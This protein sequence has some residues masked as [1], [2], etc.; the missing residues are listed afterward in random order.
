MAQKLIR[1]AIVGALVWS[2]AACGGG[3]TSTPASPASAT[4]VLP[5]AVTIAAPEANSVGDPVLFSTDLIEPNAGLA[6]AWSF[7]DGTT[8][9][10]ANPRHEY[11]QPG[12]YLVT[13]RVTSPDGTQLQSARNIRVALPSNLQNA[14]CNET[15]VKGWCWQVPTTSGNTVNGTFFLDENLGWAYGSNG[16][17]LKT[18]DAGQ[19]WMK[20][21][22]PTQQE[23]LGIKF[24]D[25][26]YGLAIAA[27]GIALVTTDG[28]A[29]WKS[30]ATE[31]RFNSS[32]DIQSIVFKDSTLLIVGSGMVS[33]ST[34]RADTWS[35]INLLTSG[36][37]FVAQSGEI[38]KRE[39][40]S[41]VVSRDF[42]RN[43]TPS[44]SIPYQAQETFIWF[45]D[46]QRGWVA[47]HET[48]DNIHFTSIWKTVDGGATWAKVSQVQRPIIT[49]ANAWNPDNVLSG[50]RFLDAN[51]GW[52]QLGTATSDPISFVTSDGG[53]TWSTLN[54]PCQSNTLMILPQPNHQPDSRLMAVY[55]ASENAPGA[56]YGTLNNGR[57]W[58]PLGDPFALRIPVTTDGYIEP[59]RAAYLGGSSYLVRAMDGTRITR[60]N[61]KTWNLMIQGTGTRQGF[62]GVSFLDAQRGFALAENQKLLQTR[63]GGRQWTPVPTAANLSGLYQPDPVNYFRF[64]SEQVGWRLMNGLISKTNDGGVTWVSINPIENFATSLFMLTADRGWATLSDGSVVAIKN[65]VI[66]NTLAQLSTGLTTPTA[67]HFVSE[68]LGFMGT[69]TGVIRKTTDGGKTW[70]AIATDAKEQIR[71]IA[72][73]DEQTGWAISSYYSFSGRV[74][75]T[76]DGGTTWSVVNAPGSDKGYSD[77]F[78]LDGQHVWITGGKG[79]IVGSTDG[80]A[81]WVSQTQGVSND[82]RQ[83]VFVNTKVGWAVGSNGSILTTASG[84][85]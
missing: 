1:F 17:V 10:E 81:S 8:S 53:A 47:A 19:S 41:I 38:W 39:L 33:V 71:K 27:N 54:Q 65:G 59:Y 84:G 40:S 68:D 66:A 67:L 30:H 72:F 73:V 31:H 16:L 3:G 4:S 13:L 9:T 82:I 34:D 29:T 14:L 49:P 36:Q 7:G 85:F 12:D 43:F 35:S 5:T 25:A 63:D 78:A 58:M 60:D 24:R 26:Q 69:T 15:R 28:G 44:L 80:G 11:A 83:V 45:V 50:M 32:Y 37:V 75:K 46:S 42:G 61:G 22:L 48:A 51:N 20:L 2:V 55:C 74:L 77:I 18:T 21:S 76:V 70:Q 57:S 62:I 56:M 23:I 64:F 52:M 79:Q 6:F